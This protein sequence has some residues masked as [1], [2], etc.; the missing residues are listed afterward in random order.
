M[1]YLLYIKKTGEITLGNKQ[2]VEMYTLVKIQLYLK[3]R[4]FFLQDK[5]T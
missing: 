1:L 5:D 2:P 4:V 3:V